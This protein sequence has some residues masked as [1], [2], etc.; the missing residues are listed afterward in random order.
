MSLNKVF[1]IGHMG[2]DIEMHHFEGGGCIGRT[3][4]AT[5]MKWK[6]KKTGE[7]KED[8]QWHSIVFRNKQAELAEKWC[9]KGTKLFIEGMVIYRQ[10]EKDGVT[11]YSTEVRVREM[12]FLAKTKE[13]ASAGEPKDGNPAPPPPPTAEDPNDDLPF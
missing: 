7:K 4:L 12:Q 5:T 3:S 8:T 1:L 13:N 2:Q 9:Q 10:Y 11:K 6:D